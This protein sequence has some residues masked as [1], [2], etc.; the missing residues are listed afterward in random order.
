MYVSENRSEVVKVTKDTMAGISS[1][2][3]QN[4]ESIAEI[5]DMCTSLLRLMNGDSPGEPAPEPP[6]SMKQEVAWQSEMICRISK[7]LKIALD[8][9]S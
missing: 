3:H 2:M 4:R 6:G 5:D 7:K 9:L 1:T 8:L